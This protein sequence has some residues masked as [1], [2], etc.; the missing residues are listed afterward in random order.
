MKS[1]QEIFKQIT[2]DIKMGI[3][4]GYPLCCVLNFTIKRFLNI[5]QANRIK[6]IN[7]DPFN[8]YMSCFLHKK[9]IITRREHEYLLNNGKFTSWI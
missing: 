5:P 8:A 9:G 7:N 6:L 3:E 4:S 1:L 2:E